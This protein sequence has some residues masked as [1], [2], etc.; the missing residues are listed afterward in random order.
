MRLLDL[1]VIRDYWPV[2]LHGLG[3]TV[4]L[5]AVVI[6]LAGVLGVPIALARL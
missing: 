3:I 4:L 6:T 2:F 1:D 5:T